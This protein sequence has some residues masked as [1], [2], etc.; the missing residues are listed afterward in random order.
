MIQASPIKLIREAFLFVWL[1]QLPSKRDK[2]DGE[3][4]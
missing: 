1:R 3:R 4:S 2:V